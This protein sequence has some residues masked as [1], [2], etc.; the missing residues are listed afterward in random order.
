MI[1]IIKGFGVS[2]F[3]P[4]LD[5]I[6]GILIFNKYIS[7]FFLELQIVQKSIT[8]FFLVKIMFIKKFTI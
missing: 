1:N 5:I 6:Y 2:G 3:D 7:D 4:K 8:Y